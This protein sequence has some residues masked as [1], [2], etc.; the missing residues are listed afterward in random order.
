[1]LRLITNAG[2]AKKPF[3]R[4]KGNGNTDAADDATLID[5]VPTNSHGLLQTDYAQT[6]GTVSIPAA[7]DGSDLKIRFSV[8]KLGKTSNDP[9][10][11][12]EIFYVD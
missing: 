9:T 4:I 11:L 8:G 1:M 5:V 6:T 2:D 10:N 7:S 12:G 3:L